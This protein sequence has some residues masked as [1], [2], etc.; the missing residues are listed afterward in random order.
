MQ[1]LP[2]S[3]K[4]DRYVTP[5]SN[6]SL[7]PMRAC[8]FEFEAPRGCLLVAYTDGVD[9]CCYGAPERSLSLGDIADV[10]ERIDPTDPDTPR[11]FV[12]LLAHA[13]LQGVQPGAG[14]Q[15]NLTIVATRA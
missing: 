12:E 5:W 7:D 3:R 1:P 14:G 6:K 11:R 9:E 8:E 15:D 13:A 4:D 10:L 2:I